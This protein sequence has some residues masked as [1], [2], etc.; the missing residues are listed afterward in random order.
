MRRSRWRWWWVPIAALAVLLTVLTVAWLMFQHI[1]A[2]YRPPAVAPPNQ[3][4]VRDDLV[5]T[6]GSFETRLGTEGRPFEFRFSQD[7]INAWLAVREAIWPASREWLPPALSDPF[8]AIE[9]EGVRVAAT[10]RHGGLRTV[11][12]AR[13]ELAADPDG[14]WVRLVDVAGGELSVPTSWVQE[15]LAAMDGGAWPAGKR[16]KL[17]LGGDPLPQLRRLTDGVVFPN[18]WIWENGKQPFR[19]TDLRFVPGTVVVVVQPLPRQGTTRL[20]SQGPSGPPQATR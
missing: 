8:V 6:L 3:Q 4:R 20:S 9:T 18:A 10:Y 7:Q 11:L 19:I 5:A 15:Q 17:Q 1:P 2:W 12:S 14:V 16:S 13:L